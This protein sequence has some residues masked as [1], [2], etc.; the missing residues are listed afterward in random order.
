MTTSGANTFTVPICP[1]CKGPKWQKHL[2]TCPGPRKQSD[3]ERWL[4][5]EPYY[6]EEMERENPAAADDA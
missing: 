2:E 1:V 4:E 6:I 5:E 3:E